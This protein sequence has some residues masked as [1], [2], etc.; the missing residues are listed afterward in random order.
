VSLLKKIFGQN[1]AVSKEIEG[2]GVFTFYKDSVD[3]YWKIE[4]PVGSLPEGFDF[5]TID[6]DENSPNKEAQDVFT[7]LANYPEEVNSLLGPSF[8]SKLPEALGF[9]SLND[10][11]SKLF[12]KSLTCTSA[13][14]FEFGFHSREGDI[15]VEAFCRSGEIT[16][17][18][19]DEGCCD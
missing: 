5:G 17:V 3:S 18:H 8:F 16:E 12:L 13:N 11:E 2:L 10:I 15:F 4:K 1:E 6:G 19:V 9:N 7:R 14:H